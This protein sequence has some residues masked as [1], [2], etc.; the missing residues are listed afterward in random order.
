MTSNAHASESKETSALA[1]VSHYVRL[2]MSLIFF[3][4]LVSIKLPLLPADYKRVAPWGTTANVRI[5]TITAITIDNLRYLDGM[6]FCR[7]SAQASF[8]QQIAERSSVPEKQQ[9]IAITQSFADIRFAK[10]GVSLDMRGFY[11]Q[12]I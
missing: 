7:D 11:T 1:F 3:D 5:E 4:C 10:R 6:H 8:K 9:M 2:E 12:L